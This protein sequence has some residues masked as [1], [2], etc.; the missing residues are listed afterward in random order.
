MVK[1][2]LLETT[3]NQFEATGL[4]FAEFLTRFDGR[5]AEWIMGNVLVHMSSNRN[6]QEIFQ[7]L[8]SFFNLYL[9]LKPIG[10]LLVAAFTMY[11]GDEVPAREPDLMIVLNPNLDRIK[12]T[13]LDGPAD[14]AIE[15]VSPES[16]ARDY[17]VKFQEY[18]QAGVREYW[19]FDPIR[20]QADIY[21][22]GEDKLYH[23]AKLD[24]Q[25]RMVSTLL[26]GFAMDATILWRDRLPIGAELIQLAQT[27]A[28]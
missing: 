15:I 11:L 17:G 19:L 20:Q 23:R 22:L 9:G 26:P 24:E 12:P 14:I 27:M 6:H 25:G 10:R 3:D 13:Y 4:S 16:I 5:H 7:F 21:V 8:I 28:Q 18:E 2:S 1:A